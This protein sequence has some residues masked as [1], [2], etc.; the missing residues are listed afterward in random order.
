MKIL[1]VCDKIV[2]K[3]WPNPLVDIGGGSRMNV[4]IV[5][6]RTTRH[7]G[8]TINTVIPLIGIIT[9]SNGWYAHSDC[10]FPFTLTS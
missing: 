5:C 6:K 2:F 3:S 4:C 8:N 1:Q 10:M 7:Q 9:S